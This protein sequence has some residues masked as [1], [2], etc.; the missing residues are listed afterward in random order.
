MRYR[1]H[2]SPLGS[3]LLAGKGGYLHS[4]TLPMQRWEVDGTEVDELSY[5]WNPLTGLLFV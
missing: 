4:L 2:D 1:Y 3:I 5:T